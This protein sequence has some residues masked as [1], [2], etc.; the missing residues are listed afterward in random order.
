[1]SDVIATITPSI[2]RRGFGTGAVAL[3]G[4]ILVWVGAT[5]APS[6]GWRI[7]L[8]GFGAFALFGAVQMWQATGLHLQLTG[9]ELRDSAGTVL[10]KVDQMVS[11]DRGTFAL[12]PSNGFVVVL[13]DRHPRAWAPG[14]WW[15]IGRRVGVGGVTSSGEAKV[16]AEV[17]AARIA[18]R[19]DQRR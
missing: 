5:T 12:K 2:L 6:F 4:V 19:P 16:M 7:G 3:L 9:D 17:L 13:T 14:L 18:M 10:A 11:V 1:M 15:R 8:L